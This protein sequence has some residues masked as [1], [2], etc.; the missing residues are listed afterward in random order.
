MIT[1]NVRKD[2]VSPTGQM[3]LEVNATIRLGEL[4][5]LFG[6]SGAGKT[7]LLRMLAGLTVPDS[8]RIT[9]G[10]EIWFD[11][12]KKISL[13]P[14]QRNLGFMFQDYAL[15]P[16]MTVKENI[17]YAQASKNKEKVTELLKSF[18]LLEF[19]NR[20]PGRL[21]GGQKQRVALARALAREP[22][23]LL[24]D[25]PLSALDSEMRSTLQEEIKSVHERFKTTT[26]M[27]SHDL[28]E[29]FRL[30]DSVV[31]LDK[32]KVSASGKPMEVF[33]NN[34]I[35]GKVQITGKVVNIEPRDTFY[36]LTIVTGINQ[37]I[38][39]VA[40]ESDIEGLRNGDQVMVFS[41]AFNPVV[42]KM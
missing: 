39:V 17:L 7:T 16:N 13:S 9:F 36:M 6:Q 8:G 12:G 30:A 33:S 35:S 15:F 37:I 3:T 31:C 21:S 1:I 27:V 29:V 22:R 19:A 10:D 2:L 38:R 11:S 18:D 28:A 14:Q 20:K 42:M 4:T 23:L 25:E 26:I 41:K 40:F 32:G 24:L 34:D 5:G